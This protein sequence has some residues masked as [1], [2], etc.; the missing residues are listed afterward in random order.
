MLSAV[1][2]LSIA[3]PAFHAYVVPLTIVIL[4]VLFRVS[5]EQHAKVAALFGPVM[6]V[7]FVAIAIQA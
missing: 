3:T 2:G 5:V 6:A 4:V 7:W 1:E